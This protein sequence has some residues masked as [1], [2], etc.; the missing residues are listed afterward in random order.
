MT[1]TSLAILLCAASLTFACERRFG[2]SEADGP[3]EASRNANDALPQARRRTID[4]P[5]A[6][7]PKSPCAAAAAD[8]PKEVL[9]KDDIMVNGVPAC[10]LTVSYHERQKWPVTWA[11]ER[12]EALTICMFTIEDLKK[13]IRDDER[14][15]EKLTPEVLININNMP[16]RRALYVE[17]SHSSAIYPESSESVI[18]EI[19]LA[20]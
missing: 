17:G 18:D 16:G 12:C 10:A 2:S 5:L 9:D 15:L 19:P 7:S 13:L 20:D 14:K 4:R 3:V 8:L 11:G 6:Q 1:R